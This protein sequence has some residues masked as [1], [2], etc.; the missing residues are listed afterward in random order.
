MLGSQP[1]G[2]CPALP[3]G[4]RLGP[5]VSPASTPGAQHR[6]LWMLGR[7]VTYSL[8]VF[9]ARSY[10]AQAGPKLTVAKDYPELI[11]CLQLQVAG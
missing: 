2:S 4:H 11:T 6:H 1:S 5:A 9:E 10:V 3:G 7:A 8:L